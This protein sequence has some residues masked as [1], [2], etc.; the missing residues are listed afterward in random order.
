[1]IVAAPSDI[2]TGWRDRESYSVC[3]CGSGN[4]CRTC[5][6]N[7]SVVRLKSKISNTRHFLISSRC[8]RRWCLDTLS[9]D[10][11]TINILECEALAILTLLVSDGAVLGLRTS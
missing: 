1:M 3:V 4:E 6:A 10:R 8:D 5:C 9:S 7:V 11:F 2:D